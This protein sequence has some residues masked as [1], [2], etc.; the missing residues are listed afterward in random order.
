[1]INFVGVG[2]CQIRRGEGMSDTPG[3]GH[4]RYAVVG[5]CQ[6][7][8]GGGMFYNVKHKKVN[9]KMQGRLPAHIRRISIIP[10]ASSISSQPGVG[11]PPHY[12]YIYIYMYTRPWDPYNRL[13]VANTS[14]LPQELLTSVGYEPENDLV[15]FWL[16]ILI[17]DDH[18]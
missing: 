12:I 14:N 6:I 3:R 7:R 2:A 4:V 13:Q 10:A 15:S 8:R 5:A 11:Y 9:E 18:I 16:I 17:Y 1:M